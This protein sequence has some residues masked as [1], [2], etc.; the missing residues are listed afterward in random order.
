MGIRQAVPK[1]FLGAF[2]RGH[3]RAAQ[4]FIDDDFSAMLLLRVDFDPRAREALEFLTKFN[5]EYHKNVLKKGDPEALHQGDEARK[6]CYARNN[7]V[8]RDALTMNKGLV[9]FETW[10]YHEIITENEE[11]ILLW[12][13]GLEK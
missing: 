5:N 11:P 2:K 9:E 4:E 8:N 7:R 12:E 3:R 6:E 13:D 1:H 10:R